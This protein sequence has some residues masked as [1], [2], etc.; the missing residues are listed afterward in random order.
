M[1]RTGRKVAIW[2]LCV[3]CALYG[4]TAATHLVNDS[5]STALHEDCK[6]DKSCSLNGICSKGTCVCD[7]GWKGS[8]CATLDFAPAEKKTGYR[9]INING[10]GNLS[11]WGGAVLYDNTT[12]T[13]FMW[14]TELAEHC[15]MHTW[16]TNSQTIRAS[17]KDPQG[18]YTREAVQFPVWTHEVDVIRGNNGEYVAYMSYHVPSPYPFCKTCTDGSTDPNCK[19]ALPLIEDSDPTYMSWTS[20]PRGNWSDPVLVMMAKPEMD[21]NMAPVILPN[22]SLVGMWR[23]HNPGGHHSTP[24]PV[25]ATDWKDPS[26]YTWTEEQLFDDKD[27]P[28]GIE[29]MFLWVDK[30]GKFHALFHVMYGCGEHNTCG[31]HAF[32]EDGRRWRWGGT[33]YT[34]LVNFTDGT[35]YDFPYV[36]RPHLVFDKDGV[37]P[38]ALTNGVKPGWGA[39]GDQSFT[40]LRPLHA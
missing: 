1:T 31:G 5:A 19:K 23:N 33:A 27:V 7:Q 13:F 9:Q 32:S 2:G 22:G 12:D 6:D 11:S 10:E 40:L 25:L 4:W 26:T 29:D 37:T 24:H 36:E 34:G 3:F 18:F 28:G 38:V 35:S 15:G 14:A 39:D 30:R 17:S 20:T 21:I 8:A 16:T